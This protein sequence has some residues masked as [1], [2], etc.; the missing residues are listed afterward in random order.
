MQWGEA[1]EMVFRYREALMLCFQALDAISSFSS[2][3]VSYTHK[4]EHLNS[5]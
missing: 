4:Y 2:L 5:L 1:E 3:L